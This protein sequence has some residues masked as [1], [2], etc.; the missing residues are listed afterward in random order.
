[1]PDIRPSEQTHRR[2]T[3]REIVFPMSIGVLLLAAA[4]TVLLILPEQR[5]I[6]LIGDIMTT[7]LC[8][9]PSFLC[10][11]PLC[12]VFLLGAVAM[13]DVHDGAE[14]WL[15]RAEGWMERLLAGVRKTADVVNRTALEVRVRLAALENLLSFFERKTDKQ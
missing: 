4:L 1:M 2:Q 7:V 14:G 12:W 5:Q 6:R 9:C 10:A 3:L 13:S 8:V 11:L 15:R